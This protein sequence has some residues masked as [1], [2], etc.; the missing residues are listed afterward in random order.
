M[1]HRLVATAGA[2]L[3]GLAAVSVVVV[4]IGLPLALVLS[5]A[6]LPALFDPKAPS[7]AFNGEALQR[8]FGDPRLFGA[9]LHS[10]LLASSVSVSATLIG[11]IYAV[12]LNRCDIGFKRFL[13]AVAWLVFV[14]PSYLKALTWALLMAPH[15]Y[16]A[17]LGLYS[18]GLGSAFNSPLGL[19]FV[20]SL[21]LFP[22]PSFVIAGALAGLGGEYEAAARVAGARPW[23]TWVWINLP[24]LA[25][26]LALSLIAVFAEVL[27]DFGLAST[28]ARAA[29]F[30][31]LTYSIYAAANTY[32]VDFALAGAQSI[33]LLVLV[34]ALVLADR[35]L[36]SRAPARLISGRAR[37]AGTYRLGAWR[38][39]VEAVMFLIAALAL[40]LPLATILVR[41]LSRTLGQGLVW[42]NFTLDNI[43]VALT[44]HH[45]ANTALLESLAYAVVA[46]AIATS[47]AALVSLSLESASKGVRATVL[48]LAFGA[49]AIPGIV[50]GFGYILLW[51]R[52][53]VFRDL[54]FPRYG[55]GSLLVLGYASAAL[56]YCLVV[57]LGAVGQL[58]PNLLDAA[59]I[60]GAGW[61]RRAAAIIAP[62]VGLSLVTALIF[63]FIRTVFELPMSQ[64]LTPAN[65]LPA[66]AQIV[67]LFGKDDDGLGSALSLVSILAVSAVAGTA[68]L[69]AR[70]L[71]RSLP[72]FR[73]AT[74]F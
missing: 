49:I 17:Q 57:I 8:V 1:R 42:S 70:R 73:K 4:L 62:L 16:L 6:V 32:P 35:L 2:A 40:L 59:R 51:N 29:N 13:A 47:L 18:A 19:W 55:S 44:P 67:R 27:S 20:H 21:G 15:G 33:V 22:L 7:L 68:W 53:P 36:R 12:A 37:P 9:I 71:F 45:A 64:F 14:T 31:L 11:C 74:S 65:G 48:G 61:L 58:S 41:A 72:G 25:P 63:S 39:A 69:I 66:P 46:A 24:L 28:I 34:G 3:A 52:T 54:P 23:R 38:L 43:A 5:Q 50:L 30:G 26:A 10:L 56:P 60:H